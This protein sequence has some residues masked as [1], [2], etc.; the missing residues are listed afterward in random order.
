MNES[1]K[2]RVRGDVKITIGKKV[3]DI[4]NTVQTTAVNIIRRCIGVGSPRISLI[5]VMNVNTTLAD[6]IVPVSQTTFIGNDGAVKFM[7]VFSETSFEGIF[8]GL[9]L[10]APSIGGQV[11]GSSED[12]FSKISGIDPIEKTLDNQM[13]IEWILTVELT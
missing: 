8:N 12:I 7:A 6:A 11:Q 5:R 3:Y 4:K 10:R 1:L 2:L 13:I 9:E